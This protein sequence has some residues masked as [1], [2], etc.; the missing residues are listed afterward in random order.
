MADVV[1]RHIVVRGRK[2]CR[3]DGG[4]HLAA[5]EICTAAIDRKSHEAKQNDEKQADEDDRLAA[6]R[7]CAIPRHLSTPSCKWQTR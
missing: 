4:L 7:T 5:V 3:V 6:L 1:A 2:G